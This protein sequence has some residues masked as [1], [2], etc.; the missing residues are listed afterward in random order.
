[1]SAI[2]RYVRHTT[3]SFYLLQFIQQHNYSEPLP[4]AWRR[5]L[6]NRAKISHL[7]VELSVCR[8]KFEIGDEIG[9]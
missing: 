3:Y 7:D 1:M 2:F 9:L 8:V 6:P 5:L 4:C